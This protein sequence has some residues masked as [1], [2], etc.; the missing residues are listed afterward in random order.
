MAAG[1]SSTASPQFTA[2]ELAVQLDDS[3]AKFL[4]TTTSLVETAV[5]AAGM[6]DLPPERVIVVDDVQ[7]FSAE[8]LAE[9]GEGWQERV[10]AAAAD[11]IAYEKMLGSGERLKEA[12]IDPRGEV[13]TLP[14]SR[15]GM[16]ERLS[17]VEELCRMK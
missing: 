5:Q 12:P 4:V 17:T 13:A 11:T 6:H 16:R 2:H 3:S 8:E 1:V 10:A 15:C 9:R 14:Y 7:D